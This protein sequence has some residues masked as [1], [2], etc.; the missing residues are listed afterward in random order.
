ME[1]LAQWTGPF[2]HRTFEGHGDERGVLTELIR[3]T[4]WGIPTGG[5]LYTFTINQGFTRGNHFHEKKHEWFICVKGTVLAFVEGPNGV[6]TVV[7][8][9]EPSILYV[10]PGC[11]HALTNN[12]PET[13]ICLSYASTEHDPLN[14]D[15][16]FKKVSLR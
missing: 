14:P 12:G 13:A 15:T 9:P 7:L 10:A 8:G 16:Y 3:F 6:E 11:S 5:Q 2:E 4:D 1:S